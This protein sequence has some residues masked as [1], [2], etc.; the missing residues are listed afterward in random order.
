MAL[1][2]LGRALLVNSEGPFPELKAQRS[3][4]QMSPHGASNAWVALGSVVGTVVVCVVATVQMD[5]L[6][7][8]TASEVPMQFRQLLPAWAMP[9]SSDQA[10][11]N[12]A[13]GWQA[14]HWLPVRGRL[15]VGHLTLSCFLCRRYIVSAVCRR[16]WSGV[17]TCVW[18]MQDGEV[19]SGGGEEL[20]ESSRLVPPTPRSWCALGA[21]NVCFSCV[22][23]SLE[24]D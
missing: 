20:F 11:G 14:R 1:A 4:F 23:T 21:P 18:C 6:N 19:G 17:R 8:L 10:G 15:R 12:L 3:N 7:G 24:G 9:K 5:L 13:A 16:G 2:E 22:V